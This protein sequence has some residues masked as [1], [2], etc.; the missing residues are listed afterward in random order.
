MQS[1]RTATHARRT[2]LRGAGRVAA[3][4]ALGALVGSG[5][6]APTRTRAASAATILHNSQ[7]YTCDASLF[8]AQ[9]RGYFRDEGLE[10]TV[11][12][13]PGDADFYGRLAKGSADAWQNPAWALAPPFLPPGIAV[14]DLV[15]TAGL[16]RGCASLL[17]AAGSPYCS[18]A[19][20][21]GQKVAAPLPWRFIF[22]EPLSQAGV[23]PKKDVEWQPQPAYN[24]VG[25]PLANKD[26]AAAM[27]L[28][29]YA[30]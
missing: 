16:Q 13:G 29:P 17:V 30:A 24:A 15:A 12:D 5:G 25:A 11:L 2:V 7:S 28:Q 21:R 23:D 9:D 18:L 8:V 6:L 26:V 3:G 10:L 14:G 1:I 27:A 20:L 19:D 4:I 22:G